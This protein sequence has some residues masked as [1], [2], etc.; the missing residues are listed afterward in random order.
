MCL[1]EFLAVGINH[2]ASNLVQRFV[3]LVKLES[4]NCQGVKG[5]KD[6]LLV[7]LDQSIKAI[8]FLLD[9]HLRYQVAQGVLEQLEEYRELL[10]GQTLLI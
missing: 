8:F 1:R 10:T 9:L 7:F 5:L 4:E 2:L 6:Y 3:L